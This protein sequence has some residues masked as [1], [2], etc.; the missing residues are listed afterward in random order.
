MVENPNQLL[1]IFYQSLQGLS[2]ENGEKME[3]QKCVLKIIKMSDV[4][5]QEIEWEWY[6]FFPYGIL[7]IFQGDPGDG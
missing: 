1:K 2:T 7:T 6:P 4:Q 3:E 5:L